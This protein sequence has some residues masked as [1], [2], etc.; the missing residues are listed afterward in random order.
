MNDIPEYYTILFRTVEQAI[1]ALE[2]QNYGSAKQ[3]LIDGERSTE[4]VF[5]AKDE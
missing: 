5:L 3:I 4:E 2:M 1:E